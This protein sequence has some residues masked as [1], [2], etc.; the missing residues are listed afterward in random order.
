M[1]S[2]GK[3]HLN[4]F[5][6]F[7]LLQTNPTPA[8]MLFSSA[9]NRFWRCLVGK[10]SF[11]HFR[12]LGLQTNP[13]PAQ[14]SFSSPKQ[15]LGGGRWSVF[16]RKRPLA[17]KPTQHLP[18]YYFP[19]PKTG[20][21]GGLVCIL[22]EKTNLRHP[23]PAQMLFSSAKTSFG[24]T[25]KE[26]T[27]L[28]SC[29]PTQNLPKCYFP[30]PKTGFGDSLFCTLKEKTDLDNFPLLGLQTNPKPAQMFF[31]SAQNR[32]WRLLKEKTHLD[33]LGP[34]A[35]KP[36]PAQMFFCSAQNCTLKEKTHLDTFG[37]LT[38]KPTQNLPKCYFP[39]PKTGFG[40]FSK[41]RLIWTRSALLPASQHLPKCFCAA[42]KTAPSRK[43]L[44]WTLS[45]P[46]PANQPRTCPNVFSSA[47]NRF[48]GCPGLHSQGKTNLPKCYFPMPKTRFWGCPGLHLVDQPQNRPN[49]YLALAEIAFGQPP[50]TAY[51]HAHIWHKQQSKSYSH[52][53][54]C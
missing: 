14:M 39:V 1:Y 46:W 2:Q 24:G 51:Q 17:C 13:E 4:T 30:V 41:K 52:H 22:T 6:H 49:C 33:T 47:E 25:L 21:G 44:I 27:H 37:P 38:C 16:S 12:P 53:S 8:Q 43:R 18:K 48:W 31:S 40:A 7:W 28:S 5:G 32:F 3:T 26:K 20:F 9:Q 11:G 23:E 45:A 54:E 36:T 29:K 19:V 35:C 10:D 34:F 15:V 50:T 42:P